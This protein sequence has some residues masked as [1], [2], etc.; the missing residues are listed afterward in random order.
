VVTQIVIGHI[1]VDDRNLI[2]RLLGRVQ[3][4]DEIFCHHLDRITDFLA[5]EDASPKLPA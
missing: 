3:A 5:A 4:A 1:P 2:L